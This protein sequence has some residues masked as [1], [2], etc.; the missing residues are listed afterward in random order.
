VHPHL[1]QDSPPDRPVGGGRIRPP[2]TVFPHRLARGGE[3]I[4]HDTEI[5]VGEIQAED[6]TSG[7]D[8]AEGQPF[9][10]KIIL[11]YLSELPFDCRC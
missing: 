2:P 7:S 5:G 1:T 3:S 6:K 8:P 11:R 10:A 9:G 4:R